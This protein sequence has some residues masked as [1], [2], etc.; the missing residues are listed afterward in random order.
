M[1]WIYEREIG[2]R[3]RLIREQIP[4]TQEQLAAKLQTM[5]CDITR[6]SVAKIEVGQR[7]IYPDE[8]RCIKEILKVSFDDLFYE[9]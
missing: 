3:I 6:S 9:K 4:M 5:G 7:H 8:L 2:N 1:N